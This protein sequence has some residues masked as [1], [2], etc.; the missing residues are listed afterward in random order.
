MDCVYTP[1]AVA[2][3]MIRRL[4]P[5][6][7]RMV[8]A[9]FAAGGGELL[10][11]AVQRWPKADV[12]AS[13]C[14]SKAIASIRR[15]HPHW[16]VDKVDFLKQIERERSVVLARARGRVR[17]VVLNPPFSCRGGTRWAI[18]TD[19]QTLTCSLAMFFV[20][21]SLDFLSESGVLVAV[22]P[23]GCL[24][25]EKDAAAWNTISIDLCNDNV[26]RHSFSLAA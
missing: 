18:C 26:T 24:K 21:G 9:D 6:P 4:N 3:E 20:L 11:A 5:L 1:T 17:L 8:I 13:D 23:V 2:D 12:I 10:R 19:G 14:D 25:S 16:Q 22:V 15:D 7:G